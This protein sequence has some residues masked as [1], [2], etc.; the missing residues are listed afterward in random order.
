MTYYQQSQV[1]IF[2]GISFLHCEPTAY[3]IIVKSRAEVGLMENNKV[4]SCLFSQL[5][6]HYLVAFG[7]F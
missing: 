5:R 6:L 4:R 3:Q 7:Y 2:I 1:R